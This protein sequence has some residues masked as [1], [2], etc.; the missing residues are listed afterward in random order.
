MQ[1]AM[2]LLCHHSWFEAN[3]LKLLD[4]RTKSPNLNPTDNLWKVLA[5]EVYKKW[6]QYSNKDE[7]ASIDRECK[8]ISKQILIGLAESMTGPLIIKEKVIL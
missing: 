6:T 4:W 1:V 2:C 8:N 7:L 3:S 5:R